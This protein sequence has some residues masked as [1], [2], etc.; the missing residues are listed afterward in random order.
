MAQ[1]PE[2]SGQGGGVEDADLRGGGLKLPSLKRWRRQ[3]GLTQKGLAERV[4]VPLD[5]VQRVEQG[6]RGCNPSVAQKMAEALEVDLQELQAGSY[7]KD[8]RGGARVVRP[9]D[10]GEAPG[11]R[12]NS[13]RYLHQAYLELLLGREV[14]SAYLALDERELERYGESLSVEEFVEVISKRRRELEV[15]E[16]MLAET[17]LHPQVRL[18]LEEVVRERPDEDIRVLATKRSQERSEEGR[19]RLT[20]AMREFL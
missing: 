9:G 8:P 19:E 2:A 13:P 6:K 15:L 4:G 5:Y 18:F 12:L 7:T 17:E 1:E 16:G 3:R 14:G 10:S 11:E 20:R